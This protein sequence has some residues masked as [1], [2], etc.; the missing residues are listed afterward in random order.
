METLNK[1][2][3]NVELVQ[4]FPGAEYYVVGK[5][6][7]QFTGIEHT[8]LF[9]RDQLVVTN[10]GRWYEY[11]H[12]EINSVIS[13]AL[14]DGDDPIHDLQRAQL[15]NHPIHWISALCSVLASSYPDWKEKYIQVEI[16]QVVKFEG[17]YFTIEKANNQNLHLEPYY[18]ELPAK[19]YRG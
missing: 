9:A 1:N 12:F 4:E 8:E 14:E 2:H 3:R 19:V 11:K 18:E 10:A 17:K 6:V 13:C 16:G 5:R 15:N 7:D